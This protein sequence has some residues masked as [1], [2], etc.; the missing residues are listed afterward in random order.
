[1]SSTPAIHITGD[2]TADR[3]LTEDPFALL[4]GMMLDQ[5]YPME[6]AF[7]GPAKVLERFGTLEPARIA[8]ADPEEFAALCSTPPAIHR[9]PG[10]MATR[11]Q[12]LAALV[13]EKYD[14]RTERLWTE[15][16][17]GKDLLKRVQELPGF[18]KQKAQIFV[19]L[20]AKQ[21]GVRPEGWEQAVGDYALEGYRSVA[22]VV[23]G[24]SLQKVRDFKKEKKAAAKAKAD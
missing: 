19:A 12:A 13:E 9:F 21:L 22:D 11:L 1:M 15:A 10:S 5:Q 18:G 8:A 17:T 20:L 14:G 24:D 2:D 16:T 23:D 7:R 3:V 4:V 6:H